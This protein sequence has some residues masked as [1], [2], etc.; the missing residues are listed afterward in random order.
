MMKKALLTTVLLSIASSASAT[1][2]KDLTTVEGVRSHPL[3]GYGLVV[4]LQGTGDDIRV[5]FTKQSIASLLKRMGV[6]I[7]AEALRVR[8]VAA[9]MVTAKLPAYARVG[10]KIDVSVASMGNAKSLT[11]GILILTPLKGPDGK[12]YASA[13]GPITVGGFNFSKNGTS[14]SK[15]HASAGTVAN[16]GSIERAISNQALLQDELRFILSQPDFTTAFR[17]AQKI[18]KTIGSTVTYAHA[19]DATNVRVKIPPAYKGRVVEFLA[20]LESVEVEPDGRSKVVINE[21]TGTVVLGRDVRIA[22]VAVAHGNLSVEITTETKVSQPAPFSRGQTVRADQSNVS[23]E[24]EDS[25]LHYIEDGGSLEDVVAALNSLGATPR[26][27][28]SILQAIKA[29][30]ALDAD[31]EVR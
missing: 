18:D 1:R 7:P 8:N 19:S 12:I 4:G 26:D 23:V 22:P 14:V 16:G 6:V 5:P 30:G 15:N 10:Q 17:I 28:I 11:G 3:L 31:L 25:K 21:R 27:L 2:L 29:A 13:Q 9:V 24:E 20:T